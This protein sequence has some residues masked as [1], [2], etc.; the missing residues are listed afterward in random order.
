MHDLFSTAVN[1]KDTEGV[2]A[3]Y[4]PTGMAVHLDG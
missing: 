2:L 3:L 4:E 1:A